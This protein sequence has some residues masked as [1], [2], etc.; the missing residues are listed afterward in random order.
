MFDSQNFLYHNPHHCLPGSLLLNLQDLVSIKNDAVIQ[1]EA[2]LVF[3]PDF[4][5]IVFLDSRSPEELPLVFGY[6]R[7]SS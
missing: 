2:K 6:L 7:C 5:R 3:M 4:K 1:R